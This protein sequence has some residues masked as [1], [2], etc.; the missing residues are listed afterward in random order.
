[1]RFLH[2]WLECRF[3]RGALSSYLDGEA[4]SAGPRIEAHLIRCATCR[5]LAQALRL[6]ARAIEALPA[7]EDPPPGF[8]T[9]VMKRIGAAEAMRA[10]RPRRLAWSPI[11]AVTLSAAVALIALISWFV[12]SHGPARNAHRNHAEIKMAQ[13]PKPQPDKVA[14]APARAPARAMLAVKQ[15]VT[16]KRGIQPATAKS[17]PA[18][19]LRDR[20]RSY[21]DEGQLEDALQEYATA[22]DQGGSE[23]AR[24]DVARVYEKSG[25]TADALDQLMQ[26]AFS[27]V[28]DQ[29]WEPLSVD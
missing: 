26:V 22:R 23:L 2:H 6:Q 5:G 20:G 14:P 9:D 16:E 7:E 3:V 25:R 17:A 12:F 19:K 1:M 15:P 29:R 18:Q 27:E 13:A 10:P 11:P 21:E 28:D 4:P 8:V 24:V